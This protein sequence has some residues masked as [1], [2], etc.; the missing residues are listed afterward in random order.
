MP[1][2]QVIQRSN[3]GA[4]GTVLLQ[5]GIGPEQVRSISRIIMKRRPAGLISIGTA[6][7]LTDTLAPGQLLLPIQVATDDGQLFPVASAWHARV[8]QRLVGH[9]I[10]TGA[11]VSV[12]RAV[13]RPRDKQQLQ[14]SS[15]AVAVDM[16]SAELALIAARH[17]IPFLVIRA[18]ADP[19][20]QHLPRSAL[21]ALTSRGD[22]HFAGL[23]GQLLR[24]PGDITGLIRL[25]SNFRAASR[26]LDACC[27]AAGKQMS[28]PEKSFPE[29]SPEA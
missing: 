6:G 22:T 14:T 10:E 26:T 28:S 29:T 13:C 3:I 16:E 5:T 7:G 4:H 19:H 24:H 23:L 17:S 1:E 20:D 18:V 9:D 25:S 21:A 12:A 15:G 27:R 8:C 11:I 2:R